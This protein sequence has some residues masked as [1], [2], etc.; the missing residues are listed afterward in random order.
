MADAFFPAEEGG[1]VFQG[2]VALNLDAKGRLAIPTRHREALQAPANATVVITAH[3][4][5]CLLVYSL[6][7]WDPIRDKLL[8]ASS[9]DRAAARIKRLLV[10]NAR[11][12]RLDAAGRVLIASELRALAGLDK[13]VWLVGQGSH[14]ELWSDAGWQAEQ[15]QMFGL[16]EPLPAALQDL[17]L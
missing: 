7:A 6:A 8:A 15:E 1:G 10:G 12:E 16:A 2:A 3:P 5:R 4:D 14:F 9:F 17:A 13:Q 11:E